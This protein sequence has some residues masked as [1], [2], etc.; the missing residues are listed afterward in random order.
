MFIILSLQIGVQA[1]LFHGGKSLCQMQKTSE[2]LIT[3]NSEC[4]LEET[5]VFDIQVCNIPRN[6][7][8]CL[9][10]YEVTK[11]SKGVKT[12]KIKESSNKVNLTIF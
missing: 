3:E 6:A 8:L 1:G 2:K 9:V 12:K 10:V 7:K 11:N 5:L 4:Q